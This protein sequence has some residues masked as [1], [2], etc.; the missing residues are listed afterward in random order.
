[1]LSASA[2]EIRRAIFQ[3]ARRLL[4]ERPSDG[5]SRNKLSVLSELYNRG[6]QTVWDLAAS[7]NLQPQSLTSVFAELETAGFTRR[8]RSR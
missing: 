8:A 2:A 5:L 1:L 6:A 4:V 3:R 7:H